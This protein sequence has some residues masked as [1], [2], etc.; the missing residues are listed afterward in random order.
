MK[1][2]NEILKQMIMEELSNRDIDKLL[3]TFFAPG[4]RGYIDDVV[5]NTISIDDAISDPK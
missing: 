3:N 1:L 5:S 4:K 2:T